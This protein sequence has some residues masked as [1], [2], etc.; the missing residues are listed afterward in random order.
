MTG[1]LIL[2]ADDEL[3]FLTPRDRASDALAQFGHEEAKAAV[4]SLLGEG[5]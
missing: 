4:F 2:H 3:Y 5:Q 1:D